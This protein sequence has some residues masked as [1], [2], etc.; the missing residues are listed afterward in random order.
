MNL[1]S[2][3]AKLFR[4]TPAP[5]RP[6]D[7]Q[8]KAVPT[9]HRKVQSCSNAVTVESFYPATGK[10]VKRYPSIGSA[11]S[12]GFDYAKVQVA[13]LYGG[14]HKGLGW[15]RVK[16][17][18]ISAAASSRPFTPPARAETPDVASVL[19]TDALRRDELA[20]LRKDVF[21]DENRH[22]WGVRLK[23][24][25]LHRPERHEVVRIW[26]DTPEQER[27][28]GNESIQGPPPAA[29]PAQAAAP[30]QGLS[31]KKFTRLEAFDPQTGRTVRVFNSIRDAVREGFNESGIY[32][33]RNH[34]LKTYKGYGWRVNTTLSKPVEARCPATGGIVF[35]FRT[36]EDIQAR[37]Y[38]I[39]RIEHAIMHGNTY[40]HL[41]WRYAGNGETDHLD[42][43]L[44][45]DFP[46][47]RRHEGH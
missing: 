27:R 24:R 33:A 13:S 34:C 45:T 46:R 21:F 26:Y 9:R 17:D 40:A 2:I 1:P 32:A 15:R 8:A 19:L 36:V 47:G 20:R 6:P 7:I 35:V 4:A 3:L 25:T 5:D 16:R 39:D 42:G 22:E 12:D 18:D 14:I 23:G 43:M 44:I 10:T 30:K 37:D 31:Y 11:A 41:Q 29:P 38:R 28:P